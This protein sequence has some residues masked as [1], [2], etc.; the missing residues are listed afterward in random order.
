MALRTARE[1]KIGVFDWVFRP[2]EGLSALTARLSGAMNQ[3]RW[4]L[5]LT[6]LAIVVA[7]LAILGFLVQGQDNRAI[8][9]VILTLIA[10]LALLIPELSIV[11]FVSAG[12]GL[13]VN[14]FYFAAG[15]GGGTGER[16]LTLLFLG[17]LSARA[18]YEYSR[19]PKAQRPRIFTWFTV[20]ILL[21]WVYYMGHVAY[22][23]LFRYDAIPPDS[24]QAALG[25]YRPGIFRYLDAHML[26]IGILP[27]IVLL[28]DYQRL[29]RTLTILAIVVF[30]GLASLVWEYFAPLPE[31]WKIVFQL[32]AAGETVEGYRVREPR[33]LNLILIG[34]FFAVYS[35]GYYK[36]WRTMAAIT[37]TALASYAILITKTRILWF[38]IMI[39]LPFVLLWKPPAVLMRQL[40]IALIA[41]ILGSAAM[42]EPRVND[43]VTQIWSETV[44]RWERNYAFGGDPRNDPSYQGRLRE[45][46][47]WEFK[48]QKLTST[49]RLFGAGLEEPYGRYLSLLEAGYQN[50][51]F[52]NIYI[53]K[54]TMHFSFLIRQLQ[55]GLIGTGLVA[56]VLIAFFLRAIQA[57][58]LV[59][60]PLIRSLVA[61]IMG[62]TVIV[63]LYDSIHT[64]ALNSPGSLPTVLLWALIELAFHW[65]RTGQIDNEV[66]PTESQAV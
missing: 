55:I 12:A 36:G 54:T 20:T 39:S 13:F 15:P 8:A 3:E 41:L 10:P 27:I 23:Y 21:F 57:F 19:T 28:R 6:V 32:R 16:T 53:E 38:G 43:A 45:K 33:A 61:G 59:R 62:S 26:W 46:E 47:A 4:T 18:I 22:I 5:L 50:P 9:F 65:K 42:L 25:F 7:N 29:L 66:Q 44:Q 11:V 40:A 64:N 52:K 51:R 58:I 2:M 1:P 31:F 14:A 63:V 17:I 34:L 49:Q 30:I 60:E 56:L 37:F 48:M 35:L 24:P